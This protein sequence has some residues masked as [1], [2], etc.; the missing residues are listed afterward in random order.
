MENRKFLKKKVGI[1]TILNIT[2]GISLSLDCP[3]DIG[4]CD[5]FQR[6]LMSTYCSQS[7]GYPYITILLTASACMGSQLILFRNKIDKGLC[8]LFRDE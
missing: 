4:V 2:I 7:R 8:S 3:Q 6:I 1:I 5:F